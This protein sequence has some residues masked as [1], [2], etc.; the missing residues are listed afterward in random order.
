M[1]F[2]R[3]MSTGPRRPVGGRAPRRR[4]PWRLGLLLALVAV[5]GLL[6]AAAWRYSRPVPSVTAVPLLD[7]RLAIP[8]APPS[9]P[10]P[11]QGA[12]AVAIPELGTLATRG[13]ARPRPT[14]STAKILTALVVLEDHPLGPNDAGPSVAITA[15][16]VEEYRAQLRDDQSVVA[17]TAGEQLTERQ[18]LEGLLLPSGNNLAAV[19]ARWDA[20]SV[21][22]FLARLNAR[23]AALGM[24][25]THF[26]DASGYSPQ[27]VSTP[28]DLILAAQAA[29]ANPVFAAI[30]AKPQVTLPVAGRVYNVNAALGQAGIV[31]V[32]TGSTPEAGSCF[33]FASQQ[34][35]GDRA[36]M[37]YGAVM[38][39]TSLAD[40]FEAARRLSPAVA[41]GLREQR[42]LTQGQTVAA[43][44]PPWGEEVPVVA[45]EDV[46]LLGWPGLAVESAL[47]LA[48]VEAPVD[49]GTPVGTVTLRL[50]TL[51]REVTV[52]TAAPLPAPGTRWRLTRQR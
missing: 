35:V 39:E 51:T 4:S 10:W 36:V 7:E 33:V 2:P 31:G 9:L 13:E 21:P 27:T 18:L 30:V 1:A 43:Y 52:R 40:T 38:G 24:T 16:E 41:A 47:D 15:A 6:A 37:V 20:G 17:V 44:H 28:G 26:A 23:A 32:K 14:G 45:D 3:Q 22:A 5:V 49:A 19:L 42:V 34:R 29:M 12:A 46:D 48:T 25:S 50:G 8:G 11:T